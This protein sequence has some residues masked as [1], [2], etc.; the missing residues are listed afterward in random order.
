MLRLDARRRPVQSPPGEA[1]RLQLPGQGRRRG[2]RA[3]ELPAGHPHGHDGGRAGQPATPSCSSRPSR[4]R[5][6][7][8]RLVE[9]LVDAGAAA[10]GRPVPARATARTS[11]R[12]SSSTP[13][14]PSSCSPGRG[15]SGS[16]S[17]SGRRSRPA[18][19]RHVKRVIAE[20]GGKNAADRRRRRRP[21]PGGSRR[22]RSR[23]S[24]TPGRSARPRRR[25]IVVEDVYDADRRPA[26]GGHPRAGRSRRHAGSD[27]QVGPV[28][29]ADAHKRILRT[30]SRRPPRQGRCPRAA[31]RRAGRGVLRAA[32]RGRRSTTP[33]RR[34][35]ATRSS[36]RCSPSSAPRDIDEAIDL[37]NATDYALTAGIFSRSP[38]GDPQRRAPRC[39]PA[40][41]TST[42][43][44]PARSSGAS[45]SAGTDC[46]ASARRPAGPTTCCSSSTPGS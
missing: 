11:A 2:H 35:P 20:M 28:I 18:G 27:A 3:L 22:G 5:L 8:S 34:S 12:A 10:R 16:P 19:Q 46:P 26:G 17:T 39:G 29:D 44:S 31:R 36:G 45:P 6:V 43:R 32:D 25:L 14:S 40:T 30:R 38:A 37:A 4:P 1:N 21:R 7:A 42:A 13:T 15:R 23:P 33:T 41:S 24:A 9:A